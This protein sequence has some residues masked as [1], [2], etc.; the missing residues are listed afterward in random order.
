VVFKSLA[1]GLQYWVYDC[2]Y[3]RTGRDG[4][5]AK[6]SGG[7]SLSIKPVIPNLHGKPE[8]VDG[9]SKAGARILAA[10]ALSGKGSN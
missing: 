10:A 8:N 9:L 2:R 7:R 4:S 1:L 5:S 3:A 6:K